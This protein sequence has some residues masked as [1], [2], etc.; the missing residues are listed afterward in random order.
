LPLLHQGFPEEGELRRLGRAPRPRPAKCR[1]QRR[2]T[3]K[4]LASEDIDRKIVERFYQERAIRRV[5]EAFERDKQRKALLVMA[6]GAGTLL[7]AR[8]NTSL[9]PHWPEATA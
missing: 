7:P 5:A 3:R 2:E 4:A 1:I 9:Q 6:T 8:K